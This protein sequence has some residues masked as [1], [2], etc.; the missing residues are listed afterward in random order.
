VSDNFCALNN[1]S[2]NGGAVN[3]DA[4]LYLLADSRAFALTGSPVT[5]KKTSILVASVGAVALS[6]SAVSVKYGRRISANAGAFALSGE[7]A[8]LIVSRRLVASA[9][10]FALSGSD[11][12]INYYRYGLRLEAGAVLLD[13]ADVKVLRGYVIFP[14]AGWLECTIADADLRQGLYSQ[15]LGRTFGVSRDSRC[16]SVMSDDRQGTARHELRQLRVLAEHRGFIVP[17]DRS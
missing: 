16:L 8:G 11:L 12:A 4:L 9:G 13:A 17:R 6:G 3:G 5:L 15:V 14:Q 2:V 1:F 10:S 7:L